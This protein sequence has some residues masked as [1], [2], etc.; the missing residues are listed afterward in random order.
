VAFSP[1]GTRLATASRDGTARVWDLE[2]LDKGNGFAVACTRI[3]DN[4]DLAAPRARYGLGEVAPICG[5][6]AALPVDPQQL[7]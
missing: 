3:G 7:K 5:D 1:D 2:K 6:H 4:I